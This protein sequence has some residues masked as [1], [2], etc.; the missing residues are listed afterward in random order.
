MFSQRAKARPNQLGVS[1][2][3]LLKVEGFGCHWH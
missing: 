1:R 2:C 3:E